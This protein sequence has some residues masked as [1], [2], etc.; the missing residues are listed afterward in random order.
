MLI[1]ALSIS[2]DDTVNA[3]ICIIGAGPAGI[4]LAREFAGEDTKV[5]LLEGGRFEFDSAAQSL[6]EARA[7]ATNYLSSAPSAG[8]RRQFGGSTNLWSHHVRPGDGRVR[9]RM[10]LPADIDFEERKEIPNSGWPFPRSVLIPY[11]KRA[12]AVCQLGPFDYSTDAW[13]SPEAAPISFP[14]NRMTTV[15]GQ[16]VA[17]DVFTHRYR[18]DLVSSENITLCVNGNV[19][20]I[21]ADGDSLTVR[22]ARVATLAGSRFWVRADYFVLAAGGLENPRLLLISNG[23][24]PSGLGNENDMVGRFLTEHQA[25]RIGVVHP[26]SQ[27]LFMSLALYDLRRVGPFMVGG[28]LALNEEVVRREGL[29]NMCAVLAAHPKGAGS[30]ADK[31]LKNLYALRRGELSR[32]LAKHLVRV[33]LRPRDTVGALRT[34]TTWSSIAFSECRGGWS[35]A[36]EDQKK[37]LGVFDVVACCEQAPN[38]DNRV[39]LTAQPDRLGCRTAEVRL[40]WSEGDKRSVRRG[41]EIFA[42]ELTAAGIGRFEPW[43]EWEGPERPLWPG[44]HH[45]MGTTRMHMDPGQ[46]VVNQDCRVHG[47]TNLFVAG[48]SV[49]PTGLGYANPTFTIL[50]LALRLAD[51]IKGAMVSSPRMTASES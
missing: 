31:S 44:I 27:T 22:R 13:G 15:M 23:A 34:R 49:F 25:F 35:Q 21:E 36:G 29:L 1:D 33:V 26:S 37:L 42:E 43:V 16:F 8:R 51:H 41:S 10:I 24:H 19:V 32:D 30:W 28:S 47:V 48:S 6:Y 40:V 9:A 3:D 12:Q 38:P 20:D 50:A 2:T 18:D 14:S 4:T 7:E 39:T 46:G 45:P 11:F 17:R 5:L